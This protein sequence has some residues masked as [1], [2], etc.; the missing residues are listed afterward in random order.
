MEKERR[1]VIL[2]PAYNPDE[3][4]TGLVEE[5]AE[6]YENILVI[7]DGCS[8]DYI[9]IFE[10]LTCAT[11]VKHEVNCGKGRA[12]KTGYQYVLEHY[13][14]ALGVIT[15][16]ADGQHTPK[17]TRKCVE[18]FLQAPEKVIMG[19]RDFSR[20]SGIPARSLFGNRVTSRLMKFFCD[21][22]LSDT[23]TGL[24]VVPVKYLPEF[25]QI[26]GERYEYEMNSIFVMKDMDIE[27]VEV[28]IEVIYIDHNESSH[29]NPIK[30]SLKIYKVFA[31]FCLSSLGSSVLDLG[32]FTLL[33]HFIAGGF[34]NTGIIVSTVGARIL[35]GIF[36]YIVNKWIFSTKSKKTTHAISGVRYLA[37]WLV[38]M[39]LSALLV[40]FLAVRLPI[41]ATIVKLVVDTILFFISYKLQQKWVF[42]AQKKIKN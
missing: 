35:S 25:I 28:P 33:M 40:E 41:H 2:I 8:E 26:K 4:M 29:F 42:S 11:V 5:L 27:W 1:V 20:S 3:K 10:K 15:V 30:D 37:L 21:I 13:P 32:V 22:E 7:N 18:A 39:S 16:D 34:A 6:E 14:D 19:V 36:N 9:P 17:D 24:R 38:Q 23:Q 12:L 31:K